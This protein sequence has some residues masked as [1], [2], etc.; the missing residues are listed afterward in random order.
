MENKLR[1]KQRYEGESKINKH[2]Q[3][4]RRE[5]RMRNN[6]RNRERHVE[7]DRKKIDSEIY[8]HIKICVRERSQ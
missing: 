8:R 7:R 3:I 1:L 6:N 5:R 4:E 2:A